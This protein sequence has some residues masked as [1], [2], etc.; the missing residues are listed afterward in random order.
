MSVSYINPQRLLVSL[1]P[2]CPIQ[3]I[4][5]MAILHI[6][7][8]KL[9]QLQAFLND[10]ACHRD[11][12]ILA[13]WAK[14]S[15]WIHTLTGC[16]LELQKPVPRQ[17][18]GTTKKARM[19]EH[20]YNIIVLEVDQEHGHQQDIGAYAHGGCESSSELAQ[21]KE[22]V[23]IF[24][25]NSGL[26]KAG[27]G[28]RTT[29]VVWKPRHPRDTSPGK[30]LGMFLPPG[31]SSIRR[32]ASSQRYSDSPPFPQ[33]YYSLPHQKP[34]KEE[35]IDLAADPL[36]R[37][38]IFQ[39][40]GCLPDLILFMDHPNSPVVHSAFLALRYLAE[41]HANRE[42]MKELGMVLKDYN[43]R[44]NKTAGFE[45]YDF[46]QSFNIAD[47]DSFNEM[48][49]RRRKAQFFF[50]GN[51]KQTDFGINQGYEGSASCESESGEEM[52]VPLQD[53]PVEVEQNTELPDNLPEDE[54]STSERQSSVPGRLTPKDMEENL[55][56]TQSK[57]LMV[58]M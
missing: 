24:I 44:R 54:S 3:A 22:G 41:R 12:I 34:A 33:F 23:D 37:R 18:V 29:E 20:G 25:A 21:N 58:Q 50:S 52:L 36:N 35:R 31:S 28:L 47:G 48:N 42:K 38:A 14:A 11:E 46:L 49:S 4:F 5:H 57:P 45:I 19:E 53:T 26:A 13:S 40:Q 10:G 9:A 6:R 39:D 55:E 16:V 51:Y 1:L 43:S 30:K 15:V 56:I 27:R 8:M 32:T 2:G 17:V 7:T